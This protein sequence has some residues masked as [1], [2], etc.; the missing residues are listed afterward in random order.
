MSRLAH[1]ALTDGVTARV[2]G[3]TTLRFLIISLL[4]TKEN[5]T[6]NKFISQS[7]RYNAS[8]ESDLPVDNTAGG[9]VEARD[10][11]PIRGYNVISVRPLQ[12]EL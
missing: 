2:V 4:K 3:K 11:Q 8:T 5:I 12:S 10:Q 9:P 1:C 7:A 6:E